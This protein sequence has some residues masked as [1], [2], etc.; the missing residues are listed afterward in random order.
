[1]KI[2]LVSDLH[3]DFQP[4]WG[5]LLLNTIKAPAVDV[6]VIAGDLAEATNPV[7]EKAIVELAVHYPHVLMVLGNHE[8]YHS[9]PGEVEK[10]TTELQKKVANFYVLENQTLTLEGIIFAGTTL[11][12]DE[13]PDSYKYE[14]YLNDF[15]TINS[16]K[17]WVQNRN[18]AARNFLASVK[19]NVVITHHLP[20]PKSTA[21]QF[22]NHPLN[23]F[24][25][26][27]V[28]DIIYSIQPQY[29]LHGHTH[30]PCCYQT[31]LTQVVA[32]PYGYP[33]E[34]DRDKFIQHLILDAKPLC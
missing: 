2:Q 29:W 23:C 31:G 17:P 21:A 33:G 1:M 22:Q 7:W 28:E 6:L 24:F 15:R 34:S 18:Q 9:S 19:A 8:Y 10:I 27:D 30:I 16:F 25:V 26:C 13:T 5:R 14:R 11:W 12:F 3:L 32:N 4:D 20:S